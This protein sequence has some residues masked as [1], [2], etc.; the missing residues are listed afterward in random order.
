MHANIFLTNLALVLCVAAV[1]TVVFERLRRQRTDP[2][3]DYTKVR[4][5]LEKAA[6]KLE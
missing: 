1:T 6:A 3:K 4:Q 5:T 2:W